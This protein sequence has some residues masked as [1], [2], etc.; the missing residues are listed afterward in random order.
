[1]C[2]ATLH[3]KTELVDY[4]ADISIGNE[5]ICALPQQNDAPLENHRTISIGN[6]R[7]C[8]LP[9]GK[10]VNGGRRK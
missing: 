7:I 3:G 4:V 1:M 10:Q 9:R 5:R 8:A 6:E 2:V